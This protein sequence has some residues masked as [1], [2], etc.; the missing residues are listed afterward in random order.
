MNCTECERFSVEITS[1][2]RELRKLKEAEVVST[3]GLANISALDRT[4]FLDESRR[5]EKAIFDLYLERENHR[6]TH[7]WQFAVAG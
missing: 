3:N 6:Q 7:S 5:A 1:R 2:F 4:R